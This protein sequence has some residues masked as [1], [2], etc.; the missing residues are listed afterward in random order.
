MVIQG[1]FEAQEAE[2]FSVMH[3]LSVMTFFAL[4]FIAR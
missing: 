3:L 2:F 4:D 1:N